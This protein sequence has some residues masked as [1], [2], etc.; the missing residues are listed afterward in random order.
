MRERK[1]EIMRVTHSE[2]KA[3]MIL[4]E[5]GLGE[6]RIL[7]KLAVVLHSLYPE[8]AERLAGEVKDEDY[9]AILKDVFPGVK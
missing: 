3:I 4:R 6:E 9:K 7:P 2:K 5:N 1:E 8:V